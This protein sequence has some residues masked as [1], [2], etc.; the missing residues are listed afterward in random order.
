MFKKG[1][2]RFKKK[3]LNK[4]QYCKGYQHSGMKTEEN[5]EG[6]NTIFLIYIPIA[7]KLTFFFIY[8]LT[9]K[10][11]QDHTNKS[12]RKKNRGLIFILC[13]T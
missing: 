7:N 10:K 13:K 5:K 1:R 12:S 9:L 4:I 2:K 3:K 8:L 11:K 6:E